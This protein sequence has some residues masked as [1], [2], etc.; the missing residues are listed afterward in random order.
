M[1]DPLAELCDDLPGLIA[2]D[3]TA[4]L[5]D[6]PI[7]TQGDVPGMTVEEAIEVLFCVYKG[8]YHGIYHSILHG[9]YHCLYHG[10]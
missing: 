5:R 7:P 4:L 6:L 2:R 9:I 1:R 8:I 3:I 10:I